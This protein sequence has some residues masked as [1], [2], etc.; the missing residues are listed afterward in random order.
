MTLSKMPKRLGIR[1][2]RRH[3]CIKCADIHNKHRAN[4][5]VLAPAFH[6]AVHLSVCANINGHGILRHDNPRQPPALT[7][8]KIADIVEMDHD[9]SD[10]PTLVSA[11]AWFQDD[12]VVC[13]GR[14]QPQFRNDIIRGGAAAR[15]DET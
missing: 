9:F 3:N 2:G 11:E 5:N 13:I 6:S 1:L 12:A 4:R 8:A 14:S 15:Y 10:A 7:I